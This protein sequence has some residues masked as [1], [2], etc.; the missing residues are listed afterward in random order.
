MEYFVKSI[1]WARAHFWARA[2]LMGPGPGAYYLI[3]FIK[4]CIKSGIKSYQI[5]LNR[6]LEMLEIEK[7]SP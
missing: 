4:Y 1:K 2:H 6:I 7:R 3:I 5:P